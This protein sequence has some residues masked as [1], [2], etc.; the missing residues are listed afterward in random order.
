LVK[1]YS[2]YYV[3]QQFWTATNYVDVFA[4]LED[5]GREV[6]KLLASIESKAFSMS[7][8]EDLYTKSGDL[9]LSSHQDVITTVKNIYIDDCHGKPMAKISEQNH[10]SDSAVSQYTIQ[11]A[12]GDVLAISNMQQ[13]Y[14]T[15]VDVNDQLTGKRLWSANTPW[16][17]LADSWKVEMREGAAQSLAT[18]PRVILIL[19]S[20]VSAPSLGLGP[21]PAWLLSLSFI[22]CICA[23]WCCVALA[24][25]WRDTY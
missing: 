14:G 1:Q 13:N 4:V 8:E 25:S 16:L 2:K 24:S 23:C 9:V 12:D 15:Q 10:Q 22:C 17:Q 20:E 18:D 21:L 6:K 7:A 19:L 5:E 11:N 3:K